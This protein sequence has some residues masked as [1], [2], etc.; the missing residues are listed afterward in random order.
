[1]LELPAAEIVGKTS[2]KYIDNGH[3]ALAALEQCK[4]T[5]TEF[6]FLQIDFNMNVILGDRK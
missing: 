2:R 1:M 5:C 3:V 6:C 4:D